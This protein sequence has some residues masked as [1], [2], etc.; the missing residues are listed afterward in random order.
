ML[1]RSAWSITSD[2]VTALECTFECVSVQLLQQR[3]ATSK[4]NIVLG[5]DNKHPEPP[6]ENAVG[7]LWLLPGLGSNLLLL[8]LLEDFG[9]GFPVNTITLRHIPELD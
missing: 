3:A 2:I 6:A 5:Y 9:N 8:E 1:L 4:C 7:L